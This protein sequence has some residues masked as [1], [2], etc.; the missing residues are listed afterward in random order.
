MIYLPFILLFLHFSIFS[1]P[2]IFPLTP[3][4][5]FAIYFRSYPYISKRA[6]SFSLFILVF[7]I[8]VSLFN[9]FANIDITS[10]FRSY[11]LLSSSIIS[12]LFIF[13]T[14]L[15]PSR[16]QF[17]KFHN[18]LLLV[19]F[20]LFVVICYQVFFNTTFH[21]LGNFLVGGQDKFIS[22][23]E[24]GRY[25]SVE[26]SDLLGLFFTRPTG[27]Y[28]EPAWIPKVSLSLFFSS[29]IL[30]FKFNQYRHLMIIGF[31]SISS[32]LLSLS[33]SGLLAIVLALIFFVVL[34]FTRVLLRL[35]IPKKYFYL[36]SL[37][38]ISFLFILSR[39][40][41]LDLI[42]ITKL[43]SLTT[44]GSSAWFRLIDPWT[45]VLNDISRFHIAVPFGNLS[46]EIPNGF[47]VLLAHFTY[48]SFV[49][50][51]IFYFAYRKLFNTLILEPSIKSTSLFY[52]SLVPSLYFTFILFIFLSTGS[53]FTPFAF[54]LLALPVYSFKLL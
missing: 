54:W 2:I 17:E 48:A 27:F 31:L 43:A 7:P 53:V 49:F 33:S 45:I 19:T 35:S 38:S 14:R 20:I 36:A 47:A 9:L 44:A 15:Q 13:S 21:P 1:L 4:I 32:I 8:A 11:F 23:V 50:I 25:Q 30:S 22:D 51:L 18:M 16:P 34:I 24:R 37:L 10:F 12:Y 26:G 3:L 28:Y 41:I 39:V 5:I 6:L 52:Q 40:N 29:F 42:N 46:Y